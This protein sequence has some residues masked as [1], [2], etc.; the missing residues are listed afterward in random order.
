[1]EQNTQHT[2][3]PAPKRTIEGTIDALVGH[4]DRLEAILTIDGM[5]DR[6][7]VFQPIHQDLSQAKTLA[8]ASK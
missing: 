2:S 4:I 6:K 8:R 1:M 3:P 5:P 7:T